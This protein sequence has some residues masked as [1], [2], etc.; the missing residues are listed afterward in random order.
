MYGYMCNPH[1]HLIH[2]I[3]TLGISYKSTLLIKLLYMFYNFCWKTELDY[4][5]FCFERL[6]KSTSPFLL[7]IA[8]VYYCATH[9]AEQA[10]MM[11]QWYWHPQ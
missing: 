11:G 2:K 8:F 5:F 6:A 4:G 1:Q 3:C 10:A 9:F 7:P